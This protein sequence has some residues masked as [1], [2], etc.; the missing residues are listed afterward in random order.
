MSSPLSLSA[1]LPLTSPFPN[2]L[3]FKSQAPTSK[4]PR[5]STTSNPEFLTSNSERSQQQQESRSQEEMSAFAFQY[6]MASQLPVYSSPPP[7]YKPSTLSIQQSPLG[8]H[9]LPELPPPPP[10]YKR[11]PSPT[12][13]TTSQPSLHE[14]PKYTPRAASISTTASKSRPKTSPNINTWAAWNPWNW[15]SASERSQC[16]TGGRGGRI[17]DPMVGR[18]GAELD[19]CEQYE[20]NQRRMREDQERGDSSDYCC[21]CFWA[22]PPL[23][24][25]PYYMF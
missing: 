7:I 17:G 2:L 25:S 23:P 24:T 18:A 8:S 4:R 13:S 19:A 10:S 1:F 16:T 21:G 5:I 15:T 12:P 3:A 20:I 9:P 14:L 6:A 11:S 22:G